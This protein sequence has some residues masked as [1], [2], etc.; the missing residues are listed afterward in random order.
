MEFDNIVELVDDE[1]KNVK[2]E[3]LMALEHEGAEYILL[4]PAEEID[5]VDEDEVVILKVDTD[6]KG[7]DVYVTI[8]DENLMETLFEKY[9]KMVESEEDE[10]E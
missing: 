7:E 5:G 8:D 2:F 4:T 10:D 9:L 3:F 1:G 6:D